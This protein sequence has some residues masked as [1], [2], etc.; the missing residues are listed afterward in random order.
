MVT[1][2]LQKRDGKRLF[3][4]IHLFGV[5]LLDVFALT[6]AL[7]VPNE[8]QLFHAIHSELFVV[9]EMEHLGLILRRRLGQVGGGWLSRLLQL[10]ELGIAD[11][12][13]FLCDSQIDGSGVF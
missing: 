8:L 1:L 3:Q 2:G 5:D 13:L 9:A 10:D 7:T 11:D 6:P 4:V 12:D